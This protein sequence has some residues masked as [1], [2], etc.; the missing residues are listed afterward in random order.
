MSAVQLISYDQLISDTESILKRNVTRDE[1]LFAICELLAD[2][3]PSFSW[4]GFYLPDPEG[5]QELVLGPFVGPSTDHTRIPY[6]RGICGQ[7]A[8]SHET[9]VAQDVH[10]EENYLAC[11]TDVQSEIV[12]PIMKDDEFVGQLD[13]D[14][15]TKNSITK[16]QRELLEEICEFLSDEF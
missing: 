14:S 4:V 15:N 3:I 12:V 6:G 11:S 7:V 10:S 13:I 1:K 9:F 5:K 16:E 2:E 8:L